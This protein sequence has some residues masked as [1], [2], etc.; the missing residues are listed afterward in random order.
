MTL[1]MI[2]LEWRFIFLSIKKWDMTAYVKKA[3]TM[4]IRRNRKTNPA[5]A[6]NFFERIILMLN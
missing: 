6:Y 4:K 5:V 2:S 3:S 1:L